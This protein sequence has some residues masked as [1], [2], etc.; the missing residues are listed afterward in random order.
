LFKLFF[1]FLFLFLFSAKNIYA[2]SFGKLLYL[3]TSASNTI[4]IIK[5]NKS[6][7]INDTIPLVLNKKDPKEALNLIPNNFNYFQN[8]LDSSLHIIT[9]P[10]IIKPFDIIS[11]QFAT[12][13][14]NQDQVS[15]LK[16]GV[17]GPMDAGYLVD[18]SGFVKIPIIGAI[19][20]AGKTRSFLADTLEQILRIKE[21]VKDPLVQVRFTNIK[22][23][24]MGDVGSPGI[25]SFSTDRITLIDAILACGGVNETAVKNDIRIIREVN[26]AIKVIH[27]NLIDAAFIGSSSYQLEQNDIVYVDANYTKLKQLKR[28]KNTFIRDFTTGLSLVSSMFLIVN[29]I[30]LFK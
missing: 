6:I 13:S 7:F 8:G 23:S 4:N 15:F 21:L 18:E 3:N 30:N 25:K 14:L 16:N 10:L 11:I 22:I 5:L 12:T 29:I 24:V 26:G 27:V 1:T 2:F 9:R 17:N 19:K 20:A 28:E